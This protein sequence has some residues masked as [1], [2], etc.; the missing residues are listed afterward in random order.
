MPVNRIEFQNHLQKI[1]MTSCQIYNNWT[2]LQE[3]DD[4]LG[5]IQLVY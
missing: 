5:G 4:N 3:A 2:D 1:C